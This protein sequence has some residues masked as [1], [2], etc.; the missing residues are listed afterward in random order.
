MNIVIKIIFQTPTSDPPKDKPDSPK[1][2]EPTKEEPKSTKPSIDWRTII[3]FLSSLA[4]AG[5]TV[6]AIYYFKLITIFLD[7]TLVMIAYGLIFLTIFFGIMALF[8]IS[9]AKKI[10]ILVIVADIIFASFFIFVSTAFG[11]EA[12]ASAIFFFKKATKDIGKSFCYL[13]PEN[14]ATGDYSDCREDEVEKEG[15]YESLMVEFGTKEGNNLI[16]ILKPEKGEPYTLDLTLSN[17]NSQQDIVVKSITAYASVTPLSALN[18][19]ERLSL[20][21]TE[22]LDEFTLKA[23]KQ[24]WLRINFDSIPEC[25]SLIYFLTRTTTLQ[26]GGGISYFRI[27]PTRQGL[28]EKYFDTKYTLP[29]TKTDAG[30]VD[31]YA[32]VYSTLPKLIVMDE[33]QGNSFDVIIKVANLFKKGVAGVKSLNLSTTFDYITIDKCS[34]PKI[35]DIELTKCSEQ[36]QENCVKMNLEQEENLDIADT[37]EID[38]KATIDSSKYDENAVTG[39]I[40]VSTEYEHSIDSED[41]PRKAVCNNPTIIGGSFGTGGCPE[42]QCLL[43]RPSKNN[44]QYPSCGNKIIVEGTDPTKP[45]SCDSPK[46]IYNF[47]HDN[48]KTALDPYDVDNPQLKSE[49]E[50][51]LTTTNFLG[52]SVRIN[53]KVVPKL[54]EVENIINSKYS[55]SGTTYEFPSGTYTFKNSGSYNFR[56]NVNNPSVLSSHSF[57]TALDLNAET[58]W[59]NLAGYSCQFDIPPELVEAFESIGF[60]WG[61]RYWPQLD[62]MHFEYIPSCISTS[63]SST[64]DNTILAKCPSQDE[65]KQK[66]ASTAKS[67][68]VPVDIMLAVSEVE[69][70]FSHCDAYGNVKIGRAA[71]EV[72]LFQV[73]PGTAGCSKEY[74][75]DPNNNIECGVK[76]FKGKHDAYYPSN[77]NGDK[78]DPNDVDYDPLNCG[79]YYPDEWDRAIRGYNGWGCPYESNKNYVN[80]VKDRVPKYSSYN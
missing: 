78:T 51:Q 28:D 6:F 8:N 33:L 76:V 4:V 17:V 26:K 79:Y 68:G 58:N 70:G 55:H 34:S 15:E 74:L 23:G 32:F 56:T 49:I 64:G 36:E 60:R 57:G 43:D 65:I 80:L 40:R 25:T 24:Q 45:D 62:P 71:G 5:S 47:I 21:K 50:S 54:A 75:R 19:P 63:S 73:T 7:P 69:S 13:K 42:N 10:L 67:I 12:A 29:S 77:S 27:I 11:K 14:I 31:A 46:N 2:E 22:Y 39:W 72:G 53:N 38:C 44:V 37:L 41:F 66:I 48:S 16:P 35:P 20:T 18:D 61:G 30:P 59:G 52:L 9:F 3:I 1:P